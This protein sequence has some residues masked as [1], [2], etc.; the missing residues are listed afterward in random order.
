MRWK[1]KGYTFAGTRRVITRFLLFPKTFSGETR[2]LEFAQIS[3][4]YICGVW[5]DVK[6]AD[7]NDV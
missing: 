5:E 7:I 2:W 1:Q 3:Q 4:M 6:W